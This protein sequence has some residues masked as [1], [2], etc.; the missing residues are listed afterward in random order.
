MSLA[1]LG[2]VAAFYGRF[3]FSFT[4]PGYRL[5]RWRWRE[6]HRDFRGQRWLVTGAS[7]GLGAYIAREAA[8]AGAAVIAVARS[9]E[10]LDSARHAAEAEGIIGLESLCCDF[11]ST[12]SVDRLLQRLRERD[13]RIDVLVNNVG[14]LL[15]EHGLTPEGHERSFVTNL[16]SHYQLTE[17]VIAAGLCDRSLVINVTSGGAYNVPLSTAMLDVTDPT[18]FNGTI[19]YAFHKRAQIAL[20]HHWRQTHR[21][22]GIEFYVMHPGWVDTEGVRRSLPKFRQALK[23]WLRDERSGADTLL[24]LATARPPQPLQELVWFDRAARPAHVFSRTRA[25][26]E[27]GAALTR[28]LCRQLTGRD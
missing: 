3:L 4:E 23:R 8:R 6:S 1:Q 25:S 7:G 27:D 18:R 20:N 17:G 12:A 24:W 14:V 9:A 21:Q 5:R 28:F 19:V 2:R 13:E 26:A 22:H 10:K 16:L 11:T 15:D